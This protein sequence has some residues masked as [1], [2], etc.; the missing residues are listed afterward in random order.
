MAESAL[1]SFKWN[2]LGS[3]ISINDSARVSIGNSFLAVSESYSEVFKAIE[4]VPQNIIDFNPSIIRRTPIE[5]YTAAELCRVIS[6]PGA[7][8]VENDLITN[9]ILIDN[10]FGIESKLPR[11]NSDL[12]NLWD[13]ANQSLASNNPDKVRHF[14]TSVRELMTQ[15]IHHLS[16]D[17]EVKKWTSN[18]EHYKDGRPT[19]EARLLYISRD[20]NVDGFQKF[21]QKDISA[22]IEFLNLFQ[23]GTH[24]LKSS[25][26]EKQLLA[27][28]AKA[29]STLNFLIEIGL[30]N[31]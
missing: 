27:L 30:E 21:V 29:E 9:K 14:S 3:Q 20:I 4:H 15:V 22:T 8:S 2:D 31:S 12:V 11:I 23:E 13:G 10:K 18:K 26:T 17:N 6:T 5:Y 28:K 24:K 7:I 16:P 19:R 1:S 25:F